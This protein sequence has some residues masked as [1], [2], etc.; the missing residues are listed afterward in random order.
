VNGAE[1]MIALA[2]FLNDDANAVQV[3]DLLELTILFLH[4]LPD[5]V[6]ML[7]AP[8]DAVVQALLIQPLAHRGDGPLQIGRAL[9][10]LLCNQAGDAVILLGLQIPESQVLQLPLELPDTQA[11]GQRREHVHRLAGDARLALRLQVTEGAHVVQPVRQLDDDDAQVVHHGEDHLA[12]VLG[13]FLIQVRT[14]HLAL[15]LDALELADPL[16]ERGDGLAKDLAQVIVGVGRVFDDIVENGRDDRLF[17]QPQI[18]QADSHFDRVH[19]IWLARGAQ[20][21]AV[22]LDGKRHGLSDPRDGVGIDP[23]YPFEQ[24]IG[25]GLLRDQCCRCHCYQY[26]TISVRTATRIL[27]IFKRALRRRPGIGRSIVPRL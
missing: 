14:V 16:Y 2:L 24:L 22:R 9:Y 6:Q 15:A 7:G 4:L 27:C 20:L 5:A 1:R 19:D 17:I 18:E 10:A 11:V 13:L 12:Q 8:G 3:I 26:N 25:Q 21:V 23:T